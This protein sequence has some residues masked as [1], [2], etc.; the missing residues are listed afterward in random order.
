MK[1]KTTHRPVAPPRRQFVP[2]PIPDALPVEDLRFRT[3][4]GRVRSAALASV[5]AGHAYA[6]AERRI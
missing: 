2:T 1:R 3:V 5:I 6:V 4:L